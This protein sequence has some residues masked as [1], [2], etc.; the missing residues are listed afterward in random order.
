MSGVIVTHPPKADPKDVEALAGFGVATVSEAMGR[1]GLLGPD[2]RPVQQGVRVAGTAVTVLS[3]PG[4]NLMIHAAVEQCGEGDILVVT[5]TSPSTDGMF[6][7]LFA[8]ALKQRGV[9]A[10]VTGAGIRDTQELREMGFAAWARAVS[11]Q[12]TVKATGGSVNVPIALDG[13]VV[14]PGDVI[15]ADDDG[16]VVVPRE[17]AR[18]TAERSAAREAKEAATREAF[19]GGQLGLDRYGL[20][21]TLERLGVSYRTYEAWEGERS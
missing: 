19:L 16:V 2:I 8:T 9:R 5:T 7:E 15:I 11:S 1:T 14:R 20:R 10:V 21:E 12:G 6:G 3:W 17:K 18:E 13:Q 4:D